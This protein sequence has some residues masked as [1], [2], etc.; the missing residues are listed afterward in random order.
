MRKNGRH[1]DCELRGHGE[2]GWKCQFLLDRELAYGRRWATREPAVAEA[3]EKQ[4]ALH[5]KGWQRC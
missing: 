3:D 4:R 5:A 2:Y 1:V